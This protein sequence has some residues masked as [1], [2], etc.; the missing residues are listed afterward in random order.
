M[1]KLIKYCLP[2]FRV[3][4]DPIYTKYKQGDIV[5]VSLHKLKLI[6]MI[7]KQLN[8]NRNYFSYTRSMD[9]KLAIIIPYRNRQEHLVS[10][11]PLIRKFVEK[12]KI[13]FHIFVVEQADSQPFNR[14]ALLNTGVR[15]CKD[16]FDYFCFHDVD[17]IPLKA[18]YS[19]IDQPLR[20]AL[21]D[22]I[23]HKDKPYQTPE[24]NHHFGGLNITHKKCF[25]DVNGFSNT[26]WHWGCEDD[27]FL[28][29]L[30]FSKFIPCVDTTGL[31]KALFHK[32]SLTLDS[33]GKNLSPINRKKYESFLKHNKKMLSKMKRGLI[34]FHQEGIKQWDP[35]YSLSEKNGYTHVY[36]S[37][38]KNNLVAQ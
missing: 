34:D 36:V 15:V 2:S 32:K 18:D 5:P 11:I 30:L 3:T 10:F 35:H 17:L 9:K 38:E 20:L 14:A 21:Q 13:K 8:K 24:V 33:G 27:D 25:F 12:Q 1:N 26:Y 29:R 28:F 22:K 23:L 6:S 19:F 37:L 31:F 16:E 7:R 4:Y